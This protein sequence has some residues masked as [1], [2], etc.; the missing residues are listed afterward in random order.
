LTASNT[1]GSNALT[2]TSYIAVSNSLVAAFSATPTSGSARL[3][4]NFTDKSAGS[5]T[6]W[7]WDFGDKSTSNETN[8]VHV[9]NK[10]GQYTV[11]LIV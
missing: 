9:F 2:K 6:S 11:S 7:K 1:N 4:V 5:P 10:T 8:P 3:S